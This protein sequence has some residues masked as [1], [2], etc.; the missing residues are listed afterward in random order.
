MDEISNK[1]KKHHVNQFEK[2]GATSKGVDWGSDKENIDLRYKKMLNLV[3]G[4]KEKF[5][6]LDVGCGY[7]H[8][9]NFLEEEFECDIEYVGI[10]LVEDMVSWSR[11]N[12]DN[13]YTFINADFLEYDFKQQFDYIV[14]NGIL[15]Q[16]LDASNISMDLYTNRMIK[17]MFQIT[18]K[19]IAFNI[20]TTKV[21]F[22]SNNLYY[23]NPSELF[24]YCMSEITNKIKIDHTYLYEYTT[25]LYK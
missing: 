8:L 7:G 19:G 17:K 6:I 20:M 12:Y 25:Y 10:D 2:Y 22:F 3:G 14:C 9:I 13:K 18:N 16:K 5:S 24:A 23:R 4:V 21:N 15:T 11:N 1:L